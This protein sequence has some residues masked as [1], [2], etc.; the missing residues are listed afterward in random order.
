MSTKYVRFQELEKEA[1]TAGCYLG[2]PGTDRTAAN[3]RS[4]IL[5]W[6]PCPFLVLFNFIEYEHHAFLAGCIVFMTL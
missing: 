5:K 2:L 6:R 1:H 4:I 3:L